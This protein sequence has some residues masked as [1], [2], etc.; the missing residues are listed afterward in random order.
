MGIFGGDR[1]KERA[2]FFVEAER[3]VRAEAHVH[4]VDDGIAPSGASGGRWYVAYD[5]AA[6]RAD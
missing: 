2:A 6:S 3:A 4:D 5:V 1:L